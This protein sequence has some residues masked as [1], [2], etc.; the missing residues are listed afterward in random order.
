MTSVTII[1]LICPVTGFSRREF[2]K[3]SWSGGLF[4]LS[5]KDRTDSLLNEFVKG[6]EQRENNF[7]E[8]KFIFSCSNIWYLY[9]TNEH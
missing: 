2:G 4:R 5:H 8:F 9:D 7:G 1:Q 6:N 3:P